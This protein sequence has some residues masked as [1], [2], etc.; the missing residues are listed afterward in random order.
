MEIRSIYSTRARVQLE[1]AK[2]GRT[3][4]SMRDECDINLI[5]KKY[6]KTGAIA[7][8]NRHG[9]NMV[10]LLVRISRMRCER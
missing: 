5:M 2:T 3:K 7:H 4:Q 1:F 8:V 6:Q 9:A 10:S